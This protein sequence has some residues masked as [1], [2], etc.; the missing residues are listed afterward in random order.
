MSTYSRFLPTH[1]NNYLAEW[2]L[3]SHLPRQMVHGP[4]VE[5]LLQDQGSPTTPRVCVGGRKT[6]HYRSTYVRN[7][8]FG[9]SDTG[10]EHYFLRSSVE[11]WSSASSAKL[12]HDTGA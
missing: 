7:A 1:A 8:R 3:A 5:R 9:E 4:W 11:S 2:L 10:A 6:L 12:S